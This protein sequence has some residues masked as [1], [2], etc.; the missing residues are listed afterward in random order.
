[1]TRPELRDALR[2]LAE[3]EKL[4][5]LG[6]LWDS[7]DHGT[8]TP[9]WHREELDRRLESADGGAFTAWSEAKARILGSK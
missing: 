7:L 5:V 3:D 2:D 6:E 8:A 9:A 1:M 4:E